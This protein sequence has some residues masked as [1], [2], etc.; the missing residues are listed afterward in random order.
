[1]AILK[2]RNFALANL[3]SRASEWLKSID[4]D[5]SNLDGITE[6]E[7]PQSFGVFRYSEIGWFCQCSEFPTPVTPGVKLDTTGALEFEGVLGACCG[8][9]GII[10]SIISSNPFMQA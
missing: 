8:E 9:E 4:F 10:E 2:I 7:V 5:A 1:M 3:P 6:V